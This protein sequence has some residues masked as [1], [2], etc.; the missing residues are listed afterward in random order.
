MRVIDLINNSEK[1]AFSFELLPPLK[2]SG[3]DKLY[4]QI[5]KLLEFDPKYINIT[6]HHSEFIQRTLDS[7]EVVKQNIRKR[8]GTV[9][10]AAAIQ[11][12]YNLPAVPHIICS[13]FTKA[14]TEYALVDLQYMGIHNLLLLQGDKGKLEHGVIPENEKHNYAVELQ[15][16]VNCYNEGFFEDNTEMVQKPLVP[17]SYGVACYP[18][19]H[20]EAPS[21]DSDIHFLKEKVKAGAEYVVTQ[22]FFDNQKY[23]AFVDRCRKEGITIPIIPGVKPIVFTNQLTVLP[24]I[25]GSEIPAPLANELS[26]CQTDEQAKQ[27]GVEWGIEQCKELIA[28]KV[29]SIHFYTLMATDSVAKIAKAVY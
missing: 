11:H 23:F 29:P 8:P 9:A 2:G 27:V 10:I 6:T 1:T 14:E 16:Q 20:S 4:G 15:G 28:A 3:V 7:G 17:F 26:K 19:K 21:M 12:K 24:K 18:E 22:M 25:F 5:D 13:G